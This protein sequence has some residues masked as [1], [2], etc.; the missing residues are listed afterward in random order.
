MDLDCMSSDLESSDS[1]VYCERCG[2]PTDFATLVQPLG[3]TPGAQ[4]HHCSACKHLTWVEWWGW[5]HQAPVN[6]RQTQQQQQAQGQSQN[7][8]SQDKQPQ[9]KKK[10]ESDTTD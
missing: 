3:Q 2:A 9:A 6:P 5:Q 4:V 10:P 1:V 7:K 8:Q